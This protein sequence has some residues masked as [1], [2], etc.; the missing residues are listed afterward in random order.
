MDLLVVLR[1][2]VVVPVKHD[3][4]EGT[5]G[6]GYVRKALQVKQEHNEDQG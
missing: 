3:D 2:E 6:V 1:A 5:L 4:C